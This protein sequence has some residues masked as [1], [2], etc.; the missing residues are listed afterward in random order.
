M[1]NLCLVKLSLSNHEYSKSSSEEESGFPPLNLIRFHLAEIKS[2]SFCLFVCIHISS[3]E[4]MKA[5][6]TGNVSFAIDSRMCG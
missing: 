4:W 2:V 3:F 6:V 1:C 5:Q